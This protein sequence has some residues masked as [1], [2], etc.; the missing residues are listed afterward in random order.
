L[1]IGDG[2]LRYGMVFQK[3]LGI[4][5]LQKRG[6]DAI[7]IPNKLFLALTSLNLRGKVLSLDLNNHSTSKEFWR[8]TSMATYFLKQHLPE[9]IDSDNL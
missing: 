6:G 2:D 8:V 9:M 3:K 5:Y 1:G 4:S 7:A